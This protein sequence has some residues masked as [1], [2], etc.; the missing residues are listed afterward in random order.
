MYLQNIEDNCDINEEL[1]QKITKAYKSLILLMGQ[2]SDKMRETSDL[3]K[4]MY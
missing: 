3:W 1:L 2:T 4:L